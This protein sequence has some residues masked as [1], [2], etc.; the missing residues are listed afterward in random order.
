MW[1]KEEWW[2]F[3]VS[4]ALLA[5]FTST[6]VQTWNDASR[7]MAISAIV[8]QNT[9]SIDKVT[10]VSTGDKVFINGH[11]YSDKPALS[12]IVG[13]PVYWLISNFGITF[14]TSPKWAYFLLSFFTIGITASFLFV[15][16]FRFLSRYGISK[17][18]RLFYTAAMGLGTLVFPYSTLF[19]SHLM[20]GAF[21]FFSYYCLSKARSNRE[22]AFAGLFAG[23]TA[24]FD[25]IIGPVFL[26]CFIALLL[27]KKAGNQKL[28]C[29]I[30]IAAV[31]ILVYAGI[32][33]SVS[34]SVLPFNFDFTYFN[35]TGM[36]FEP[37]SCG[38]SFFRCRTMPELLIY[39]YDVVIGKKGLFSYSPLL[40][41]ALAGL[42]L[43][44]YHGK[45]RGE[46]I[47]VSVGVLLSILAFVAKT[48]DYGGC[49]FGFRHTVALIPILFAYT[50]LLFAEKKLPSY[51]KTLFVLVF[52][53]S[54]YIGLMAII[55]HP[56]SC[57]HKLFLGMDNISDFLNSSL[58][59]RAL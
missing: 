40:L 12:Y 8:D 18:M 34:R 22:Y 48:N 39:A 9:L 43:A 54:V 41:F 47:A 15:Y 28:L 57:S 38:N 56:F 46:A 14:Y 58:S 2:I 3:F 33:Y 27:W 1:G 19:N 44:I 11:F 53:I 26:A 51:W 4:L 10:F 16:F 37:D 31:P 42:I 23:L 52:I 29:F 21:L 6:H 35:Y 25:S 59:F 13:V 49:C 20:T 24:C 50:P 32:N 5:V 30:L 55:Q 7:M 36:Q 17:K 45:Y